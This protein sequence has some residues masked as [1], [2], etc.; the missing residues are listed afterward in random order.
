MQ[1]VERKSLMC[2]GINSFMMIMD[3]GLD[4]TAKYKHEYPGS[5]VK[6]WSSPLCRIEAV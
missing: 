5:E 2:R 4:R 3:L 1:A 6:I